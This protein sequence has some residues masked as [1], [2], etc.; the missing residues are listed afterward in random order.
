MR[1]IRRM[2]KILFLLSAIGFLY[3]WGL[4]GFTRYYKGPVSD[5]FDGKQFFNPGFS[6]DKSREDIRKW[7]K[8]R[9]PAAWPASVKNVPYD[10]PPQRVEGSDLRVTFVGHSTFLIQTAGLNIL[11]DPIWSDRASPLSFI[12][13]M[14][15][16]A[17]GIAF[18]VLPKIDLVLVSH[19][20]YDHLDRPTLK[21]IWQRDQPVI[22]TPLGNDRI[23]ENGT[24]IKGTVT[25]DWGQSHEVAQGVRVHVEQ[26]YHWSARG[27][28]D[29]RKALWGGFVI[30]TPGGKIYFAGDT[31]FR[32]GAAFRR[33]FEKH[34]D[35][36]F[37]ILPVGAYEPRWFM[38]TSHMNPDEAVATYRL[39][40]QPATLGAHYGTIQLTDEGIDQPRTDLEAALAREG[41]PADKFRMLDVGESITVR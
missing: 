13:P 21:R 3:Y 15:V 39:M 40:G 38:A 37:A 25:L 5:H 14:R 33:T 1:H 6:D 36:R 8:T 10:V 22:V 4:G 2:I 12:G 35:F 16:R 24:G 29:R 30:D 11:L 34:G 7:Q 19:N 23:I 18:D 20:H 28:Y 17:P 31:G 9:Q 32:D 41:I 26:V 27:L